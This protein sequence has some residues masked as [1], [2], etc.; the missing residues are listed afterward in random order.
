MVWNCRERDDRTQFSSSLTF[1][2]LSEGCWALSRRMR[3][4]TTPKIDTYLPNYLTL[5]PRKPK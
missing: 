2:S 3:Q 5:H 4:Q 1:T